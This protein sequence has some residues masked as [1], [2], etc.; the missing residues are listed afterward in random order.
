[1]QEDKNMFCSSLS[2]DKSDNRKKPRDTEEQSVSDTKRHR[3]DI[4]KK[5]EKK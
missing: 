2:H 3:G 1:M 5:E 4:Y